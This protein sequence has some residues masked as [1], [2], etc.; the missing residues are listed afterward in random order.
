MNPLRI[1]QLGCGRW[2]QRV[3][4][5]IQRNAVMHLVAVVDTDPQARERATAMANGVLVAASAKDALALAD[6]AVVVT[7]PSQHASNA[8]Q[9]L[10]A[11]LHVLVENRSRTPV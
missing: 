8:H 5:A 3:L 10:D 9:L 6:A 2:G 11:G 4:A 7:P 1:M